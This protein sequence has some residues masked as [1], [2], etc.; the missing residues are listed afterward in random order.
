MLIIVKGQ[1]N[2]VIILDMTK[3]KASRIM[4]ATFPDHFPNSLIRRMIRGGRKT[5]IGQM[6]CALYSWQRM[7]LASSELIPLDDLAQLHKSC[8][9]CTG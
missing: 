2:L 8:R 5:F 7:A 4:E 9:N 6:E 3:L 1:A